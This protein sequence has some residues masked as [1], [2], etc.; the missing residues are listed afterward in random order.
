MT[1]LLNDLLDAILVEPSGH[2]GMLG[3]HTSLKTVTSLNK[4]S[5]L[6]SFHIS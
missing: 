2:Q 6:L 5:R 4:E 1:R 3:T